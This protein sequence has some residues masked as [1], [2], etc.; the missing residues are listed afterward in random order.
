MELNTQIITTPPL[1][2]A[3]VVLLRDHAEG[4]QVLLLRRHH[5][6]NV[7]GGAYVFPGGK[8]DEADH[9]ADLL[10]RLSQDDWRNPI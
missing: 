2:S 10:T 5:A 1:D 4:L 9:L 3:S 8:L 7:L 6:S